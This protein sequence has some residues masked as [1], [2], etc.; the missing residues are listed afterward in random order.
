MKLSVTIFRLHLWQK[1]LCHIKKEKRTQQKT[2][3]L[4]DYDIMSWWSKIFCNGWGVLI[5]L[6]F[7]AVLREM[8][9]RLKIIIIHPSIYFCMCVYPQ[10]WCHISPYIALDWAMNDFTFS[11]RP[12]VLLILVSVSPAHTQSHPVYTHAHT[13]VLIL[14][15]A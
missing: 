4:P 8:T 2:G 9:C 10:A 12:Q 6:F 11:T 14:I 15:H 1:L 13:N 7:Q 5:F 3:I